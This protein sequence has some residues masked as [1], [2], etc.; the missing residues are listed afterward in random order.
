MRIE[1]EVSDITIVLRGAFNP[2]IFQPFWLV[3]NDILTQEQGDDAKI[4]II[5]PEATEF[6]IPDLFSLH[7]DLTTF[8]INRTEAPLIDASDLTVKIFS[9]LLPHTP[10]GQVGINRSVHFSVGSLDE[11]TR[12]GKLLAPTDPWG[13][14]GTELSGVASRIKL[15]QSGG[16]R[17]L[18]MLQPQPSDRQFGHIQATLEPSILIGGGRSGIFMLINDHY[19]IE[20]P[21]KPESAEEII[22]VLS[23]HFDDSVRRSESIIDQIMALRK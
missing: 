6:L 16:L 7:V 2:S 13:D 10:I 5:H 4:N 3:S 15:D 1:P 21:G 20:N 18:T 12:I 17:S 8:T 14:W 9:E 22:G 11:R 19:Q 23:S